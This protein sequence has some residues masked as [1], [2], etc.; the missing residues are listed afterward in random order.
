MH[1]NEVAALAERATALVAKWRAMRHPRH[2]CAQTGCRLEDCADELEAFIQ[3]LADD[4]DDRV[5][6]GV[7]QQAREILNSKG[8][9][10]E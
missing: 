5:S 7:K 3:S 4:R 1:A 6:P 2:E 9:T 8:G 10:C